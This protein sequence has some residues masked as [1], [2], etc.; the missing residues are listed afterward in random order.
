MAPCLR[1][2]HHNAEM[3]F[4]CR[5]IQYRPFGKKRRLKGAA[6]DTVDT[7]QPPIPIGPRWRLDAVC[8]Y[9]RPSTSVGK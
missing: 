7:S 6:E 9:R 5:L 4:C 8:H 3:L 1:D 2:G